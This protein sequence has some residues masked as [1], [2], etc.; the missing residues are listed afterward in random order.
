MASS[1]ARRPGRAVDGQRPLAPAQV[2]RLEHPEDPEPVVE[3]VVGDED[4]VELRQPDRAQELL[5]GALAAVEQ[6]AVAAGAQQQ[7]G[8]AAAR[9]RDRAGGAGEEER[10]VHAALRLERDQL[11]ARARPS[12]TRGDPHRVARRAAALGR[13][14]GVE[15]LEAVA[16]ASCSGRC[17]WPNTTAS[18]SVKRAAHALEPPGAGPGVVDH[19]DPHA[20]GS[21]TRASGS[22]ALQ[23]PRRRRCRAPRAPAARA[24][25]SA[26]STST[27]MKSPACRIASAAR[28]RSTAAR[29]Q[30]RARRAAGGCRR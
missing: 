28:S 10:E 15:D 14:A 1:S 20:A 22:R 26:C 5:L 30:R 16:S 12:S 4:R 3:V 9:G 11:E 21:T 25:R 19:P 17:E 24:P 7:R 8:Q 6:E 23:R 27:R 13:R 2:E 18:A 29:R